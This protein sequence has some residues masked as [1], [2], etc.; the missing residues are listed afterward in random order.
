MVLKLICEVQ[1]AHHVDAGSLEGLWSSHLAGSA[2]AA[3]TSQH[4]VS[5]TWP[6]CLSETKRNNTFRPLLPPR[7]SIQQPAR[8][9]RSIPSLKVPPTFSS[10]FLPTL[11]SFTLP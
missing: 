10:T 3:E 1:S 6:S 5:I 7:R 11:P 4:H 2:M 9:A 8:H